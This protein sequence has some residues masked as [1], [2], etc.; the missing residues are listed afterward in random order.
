VKLPFSSLFPASASR[1]FFYDLQIEGVGTKTLLAE[2]VGKYDKIGIDGVAMTV[3]DVIRSGAEPILVSD[4]I[5]IS[6]SKPR[7]LDSLVSGVRSGAEKAGCTLASGE[8]GDVSEILHRAISRDSMPFDL[9]VSCLGIVQKNEIILG[10]I[11]KGNHIIG[12][13]SSGIH[14]NGLTMARKVLLKK[15]GGM[16]EPYDVPPT[17]GRPVIEELLEPTRIYVK[18]LNKLKK[19]GLRPSAALHV[20]GDGLAKFW[21]LLSWQSNS[22]DLGLKLKMSRK[23]PI[24][25]LIREVAKR[26]GKPISL[27]EMFKTFNMG[28]GFAFVFSS[29]E[30]ERALD[31]LNNEFKSEKIGS[32]SGGRKISIESPFAE[33]PVFL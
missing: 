11:S 29:K 33:K 24:F 4:A 6:K 1:N 7:I 9:F 26:L 17:I 14:S 19:E 21:R 23:P 15:W 2:L 20:T 31:S 28:I 22:F 12:L 30:S 32:V 13:E 25:E 18:A 16:Y 10:H 27:V 8:T 5:H 3:N